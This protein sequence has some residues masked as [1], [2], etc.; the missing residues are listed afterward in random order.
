MEKR[1]LTLYASVTLLLGLNGLQAQEKQGLAFAW[2]EEKKGK[3][4]DQYLLFC[5]IQS[6][7][8]CL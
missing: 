2:P 5:N 7:S 4:H 3:P 8:S 6:A 1:S